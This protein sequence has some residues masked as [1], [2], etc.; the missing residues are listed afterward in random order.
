M[1]PIGWNRAPRQHAEYVLVIGGLETHK[2]A[3][4]S[5]RDLVVWRLRVDCFCSGGDYEVE[6][7]MGGGERGDFIQGNIERGDKNFEVEF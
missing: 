2:S 7:S 4:F 6:E 1:K 3:V 5:K